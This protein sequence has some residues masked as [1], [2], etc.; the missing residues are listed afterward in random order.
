MTVVLCLRNLDEIESI[1]FTLCLI[2]GSVMPEDLDEKD[3]VSFTCVSERVVLC[4]RNLD[5]KDSVSFTRTSH[6]G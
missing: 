1:S 5:E 4:L 6:K 2:K 3:Y